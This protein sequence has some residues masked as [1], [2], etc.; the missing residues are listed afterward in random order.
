MT[1]FKKKETIEKESVKAEWVNEKPK[2][3]YIP[4]QRV[5]QFYKLYEYPLDTEYK[6]YV[7]WK[8]VYDLFALDKNKKYRIDKDDMWTPYVEEI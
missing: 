2:R 1:L 7:F 6:R 8:F 5:A 3:Y 4:E